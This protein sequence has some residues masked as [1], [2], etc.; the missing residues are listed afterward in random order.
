VSTPATKRR[1]AAECIGFRY[2]WDI[3]DVSDMRYQAKR[4]A[5]AIYTMFDGYVCCQPAGVNPHLWRVGAVRP[6]NEAGTHRSD[7]GTCCLNAVGIAVLQGGEDVKVSVV[8]R[9]QALMG[10]GG[11]M[12]A[13]QRFRAVSVRTSCGCRR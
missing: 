4:G 11:A 5:L 13:P 2:S 7:S 10:D 6:L 8:A 9:A 12:S 3:S 1:T